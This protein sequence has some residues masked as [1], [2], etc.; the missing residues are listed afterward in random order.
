LI[1]FDYWTC[2]NEAVAGRPA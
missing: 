2:L 1:N